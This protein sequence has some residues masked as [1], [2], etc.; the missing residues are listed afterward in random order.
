LS[1][2]DVLLDLCCGNGALATYFFARCSG[3][4]GVDF[5]EYLI[6]V[7]R[8]NFVRRPQESFFLQD[9]VEFARTYPDP[10]QFT[11]AVCYGS[12]MF[13]PLDSIRALL[14]GLR[15]R[16]T[17]LRRLFI[18]N[19]PDKA[20]LA[21]FFSNGNYTPGIEN[22]PGSPIGIWFAQREF[23]A[24]AAQCG[25]AATILRMPESFYAADYRFDAMLVPLDVF[26]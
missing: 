10:Q 13:L 8:K 7:A 4:L 22:D 17:S 11:K 6:E 26:E 21:E 9:V 25:W 14:A 20:M 16:F 1:T 12:L 19:L 15:S 5:S 24:L 3:G 2:N 23:I 18:G